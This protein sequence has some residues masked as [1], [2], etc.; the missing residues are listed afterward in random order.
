[1]SVASKI[2]AP[3]LLSSG[4]VAIETDARGALLGVITEKGAIGVKQGPS[5]IG[6]S[7]ASVLARK[8]ALSSILIL[9]H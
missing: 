6:K 4:R 1:M 5:L 9:L 7:L 8:M 2:R 3:A